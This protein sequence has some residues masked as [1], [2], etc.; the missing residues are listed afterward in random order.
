[1]PLQNHN[2]AIRPA[3][4]HDLVH[5]LQGGRDHGTDIPIALPLQCQGTSIA[6]PWHIPP[7]L[8]GQNR[9]YHKL[10]VAKAEPCMNASPCSE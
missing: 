7:P 8:L 4:C 3:I 6:Q 2:L 1:M 9:L 5:G 10:A